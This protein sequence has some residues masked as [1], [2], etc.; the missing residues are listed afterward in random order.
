M[1][2][3]DT[4]LNLRVGNPSGNTCYLK[5]TVMLDDGTTLYTSGL[6]EPG[7]G[8]ESITLTQTLTTG[9]YDARVHY[10]AYTLDDKKTPLNS[11]D[12]AFTLT[13]TE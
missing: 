13:V 9:S 5:A 2:T 4:T 1:K 10:Q 11:A 7:K 8:F 3:G 6:L 12:S